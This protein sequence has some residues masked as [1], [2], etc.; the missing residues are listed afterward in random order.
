MGFQE[1][2]QFLLEAHGGLA[3]LVKPL[4]QLA[5]RLGGSVRVAGLLP[6]TV[7]TLAEPVL[8]GVSPD[9]LQIAMD[10]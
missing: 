8:V 6:N 2:L 9:V 10:V 7:V 3:S 5:E 1:L 4:C